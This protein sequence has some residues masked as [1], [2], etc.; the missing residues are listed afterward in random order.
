MRRERESGE[1]A[2]GDE[3]GTVVAVAVSNEKMPKRTPHKMN[4]RLT[5]TGRDEAEAERPQ[6]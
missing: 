2:I 6:R 4:V 1:K 5:P 3:H